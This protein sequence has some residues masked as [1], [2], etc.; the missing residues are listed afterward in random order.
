LSAAPI[1]IIL[2]FWLEPVI[3]CAARGNS[4]RSGPGEDAMKRNV[5]D[6]SRFNKE[7]ILPYQLRLQDFEM[8][9]QDIY[10]F[11]HDVNGFMLRAGSAASFEMA[12]DAMSK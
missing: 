5:V 10:D 4:F 11:F 6:V 2:S 3:L 7:A 12:L 9:M 8:A 1:F